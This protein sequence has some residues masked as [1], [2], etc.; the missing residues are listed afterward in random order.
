MNLILK[1]SLI[2]LISIT[3][4]SCNT[5]DNIH[6]NNNHINR[7]SE[8]N[9]FEEFIVN[10]INVVK[11]V[12]DYDKIILTTQKNDLSHSDKLVFAQELGFENFNDL[13]THYL[14]QKS[15]YKQLDKEFN[16]SAWSESE[17]QLATESLIN[18]KVGDIENFIL[19]MSDC[20][21]K[22]KRRNCFIVGTTGSIAGQFACLAADTTVVLGVIC[23]G[24]VYAGQAAALDTCNAN[25]E[26]CNNDCNE[27]S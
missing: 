3:I 1:T 27:N 16:V 10:E 6:V 11:N 9:L 15:I 7:L 5:D 14:K 17:I 12:K 2:F 26:E 21:C 13:T 8:S 19:A 18:K 22:R 20:N 23:H 4:F 25:F 24:A